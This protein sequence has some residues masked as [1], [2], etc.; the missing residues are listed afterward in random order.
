M[1]LLKLRSS[2]LA[3]RACILLLTALV[4]AAPA[5][6]SPRPVGPTLQATVVDWVDGDTARVITS[7]GRSTRVRLIGIDTPEI[8]PSP[9]ATHQ[10]QRLGVPVSQILALGRAA[11]D[12][13][14]RLAPP[15][16]FVTLELDT[17]THDRYG[18]LLAYVWTGDV[19]VN[20]ELARSGY[21][22]PLTV[23][24]NVRHARAIATA[25]EQARREGRSICW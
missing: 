5:T 9:R 15:G 19:L 6:G 16:S 10:A 17:Q 12:R 20:L 2:R 8:S 24:P 22:C 23:P 25:A 11:R 4:L 7:S 3:S 14:A 18:R 1:H 13:A 21:A